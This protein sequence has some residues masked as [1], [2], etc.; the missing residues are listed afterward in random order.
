MGCEIESSQGMYRV[1]GCQMVYFQTKK[2]NLGK[3]WSVCIAMDDVGIFL[4]PFGR[5]Y[6]HLVYALAIWY[7]CQFWYFVARKIW[8]PWWGGI[9]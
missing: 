8:Q 4:C 6:A 3:F 5:F 7:I 2:P 1:K 9:F